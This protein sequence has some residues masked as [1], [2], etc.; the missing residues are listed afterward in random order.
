MTAASI[1]RWIVAAVLCVGAVTTSAAQD[2][3]A[4]GGWTVVDYGALV[5]GRRLTHSG[6]AIAT[7]LKRLG[8]RP[9]PPPGERPADAAAHRVLEPLLEPY[10]FVL[11]DAIDSARPLAERPLREVASLWQPGER[12]PAWVELLRARRFVV[13]SDGAGRFRVF[14]PWEPA[15]EAPSES[16]A[17]QAW[18]AAWPVLRHVVAAELRRLGAAG[19]D[20]T[21]VLSV[22]V[23][24][25]RHEPA[26]TRFVLGTVPATVELRDARHLGP[27]RELDLEGWRRFL[28]GGLLLEG[29][30]LEPDGQ[31]RLLGSEAERAPTLL[32]RPLDLADF[33]V[34]Y[35]A[36]F[37]GGLAKPYMSLDRALSPH[38]SLVSYGG[39]LQ[40]TSL[41]LVSLLCDIRFKTF[42]MGI[43]VLRGTDVREEVRGSLEGF[44]TH[45]ERLS[46]DP[47]SRDVGGQQTRLWFYPDDV[48]LT[49]SS[50]GDVLVIRR[51]RM[52]AASERVE[53]TTWTASEAQDPPWTRETIRSINA[54]YD[55]LTRAFP[56]LGDLDQTV[57][58]LALFSWLELARQEGLAVPDLDLLLDVELPSVPTPRRFPQLLA[59][60]ALPRTPGPGAVDV[61]DR[62]DVGAALDLLE[63]L[64]G[65]PLPAR[66]RLDRALAS[67][68]RRRPDHAALL[69]EVTKYDLDA[70]GDDVLDLLAYRAER[71]RMHQLVLTTLPGER[72]DALAAREK[73]GEPLRVFSVGIGGLDLSMDGALDRASGRAQTGLFGAPGSAARRGAPVPRRRIAVVRPAAP[74]GS[75]G[76]PVPVGPGPVL[77]DH[78][79]ERKLETSV[80]G[81]T[82]RR[83]LW[84]VSGTDGPDPRAR[85]LTL[86]GKGRVAIFERWEDGRLLTY[87]FEREEGRWTASPVAPA[88][89]A[90]STPAPA[91]QASALPAGLVM[92]EAVPSETAAGAPETVEVRLRFADR[93][94]AA[95]IPRRVL[96]RLVLGRSLDRFRRP[97]AGLSPLPDTLGEVDRV[98]VYLEPRWRGAPWE[99]GVAAVPGEEDPVRLA[100]AFRDWW[101]AETQ[102]EVPQAVVIAT[103]RERS[104]ARWNDAPRP[105][106]VGLLLLPDDGFPALASPYREALE[107]AWTAGPVAGELSGNV[108]RVIVLV[109]GEAPARLGARVR[110]LANDPA[111]KGR[112]LAVVSLSGPLRTDVV[113][114]LAGE[115]VAAIGLAVVPPV[116]FNSTVAEIERTGRALAA[117]TRQTRIEDLSDLF[118]WFF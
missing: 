79:T 88:P 108:P 63:P 73:S 56:E 26:L 52:T 64:G 28:D 69:G 57:R 86:D 48:D 18:L 61:V 104:A 93:H 1:R 33:A 54:E 47:T 16:A 109:S 2:P 37:H 43:D 115:N 103:H 60:N 36:V 7:V 68:D 71:L 50:Q 81:D 112:Y 30:K 51:A 77:P 95:P 102:A 14:A 75:A 12:Q 25:Y 44:R 66:W 107:A 3:G 49:L 29:G 84:E 19:E 35:R 96:Q 39:R 82:P 38:E 15:I 87:R 20:T 13:E 45:L 113:A 21:P 114:S 111:M 70:L 105:G 62:T 78:G 76:E 10:A 9:L 58:L 6:E 40:D 92:I 46:S 85:R 4:A 65:R 94:I 24:P 97:L 101:R 27:R 117:S 67:L 31:V 74:T 72:R 34:A 41:G 23:F 59:F 42:S 99:T 53:E 22:E 98:M 91:G 55:A 106:Q 32:G 89:D 80:S 110:R 118:V 100:A 11:P 17:R 5:D 90:R 116:G 8:G 83:T